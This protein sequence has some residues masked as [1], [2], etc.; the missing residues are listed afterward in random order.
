MFSK[1]NYVYQVYKERNFTR[2]AEKLYIS[3]PSLSVAIKNIERK[4]GADLFERMGTTV[5]LT[6]IGEEYIAT[7]KQIIAAETDFLNRI[8]DINNLK[9]GKVVV[10]GTNYLSSYVLPR[11]INRFNRLYPDIEVELVEANSYNL[12]NMVNNEQVDI[13]I[14]SFDEI[15]DD[16]QG[17]FLASEDILLCVPKD[18]E[19]NEKLKKY[20]IKPESI[21]N[22]SV[23]LMNVEGVPMEIFKNEKFI[24]LKKGNDMCKR[25]MKFFNEENIE[26]NVIYRVDQLNISY[27]LADSGIGLCFITDTF[28]KYGRGS[29]NV[30]LYKVKNEQYNRNLYVAYKKN[31][32]CTKAME[33]F[34]KVT[35]EI[36][37]DSVN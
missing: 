16:Y 7:A 33:E 12:S 20:Q 10:G 17:E 14:D 28:F 22:G 36:L 30:L 9:K 37:G 15:P 19:I 2:A 8:N 34:I 3:Q 6:E 18:R 21:Y 13:I 25:A 24:L 1:Y 27:A 23:R 35:K 5:K 29:D 4:I 32:Y 26:P 31:R 11:V